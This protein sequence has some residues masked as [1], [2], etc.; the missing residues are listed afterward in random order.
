[1]V[2]LHDFEQFDPVVISDLFHICRYVCTCTFVTYADV[3]IALI[4][5][6]YPLYSS[7]L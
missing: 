4:Y 2:F 7:S 6:T 5:R 1:M 3:S